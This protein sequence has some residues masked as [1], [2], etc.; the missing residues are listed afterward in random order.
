[1]AATTDVDRARSALRE[2]VAHHP[3]LGLVVLFGSR[4]RQDARRASDWDF[5]FRAASGFDALALRAALVEQL[6]TDRLD[7]ADLDRASGLLR[8][9]AARDGRVLFEREKGSFARF[10]TDAVRFW[11]DAEPVLDGSY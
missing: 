6:G 5:G 10:W 3:R 4:G 11:C 9:R 8:Y 2:V 1:M 7:L